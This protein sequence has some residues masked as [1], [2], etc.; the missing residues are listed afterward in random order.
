MGGVVERGG[1]GE[2]GMEALG[3]SVSFSELTHRNGEVPQRCD[4]QGIMAHYM[5][6]MRMK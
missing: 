3:G 5:Q 2:F 1:K 6:G 4:A